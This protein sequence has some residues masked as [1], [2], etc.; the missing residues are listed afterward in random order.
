ML[1]NS[2]WILLGLGLC[3]APVLIHLLSRR[4]YRREPWAAMTFLRAALERRAKQLRLESVLLL[5]LRTLLV[6]LVV[7]AA[8]EPV[9]FA[10]DRYGGSREPLRRIIVVDLSASMGRRSLD[11]RPVDRA[12]REIEEVLNAAVPGD[13]FQLVRIVATPPWTLIRKETFD[14]QDV[15]AEL[16]RWDLTEERGDLE[17]TL[18]AVDDLLRESGAAASREVIVLSDLQRSNWLP[19]TPASRAAQQRLLA[20]IAERAK[21]RVVDVAVEAAADIGVADLRPAQPIASPGQESEWTAVLRN[22]GRATAAVRVEW[23]VGGELADSGSIDV[24]GQGEAA[25]RHRV[26]VADQETLEVEARLIVEDALAA[27]N[28]RFGAIP[29]RS[30]LKVVLVDGR[31]GLRPIDGAAGYLMT[32]LSRRGGSATNGL[33]VPLDCQ[34]LSE[35]ELAQLDLGD[36]DCLWLCDVAQLEPPVQ[37]RLEHFVER[38]GGLVVS[39]GDQTN[40]EAWN[41]WSGRLGGLLPV[42]LLPPRDAAEVETEG[43][44]FTLGTSTHPVVAPFIGNPD[45][46]LLTTRI[47]RYLDAELLPVQPGRRVLELSHGAPAIVEQAYGLGRVAVVLTSVDGRWE[48]WAVW[49]S[50]PP[51]VYNLAVYAASGAEPRR[52]LAVGEPIERTLL[53]SQG[54]VETTLLDPQDRRS[55][56]EPRCDAEECRVRFETTSAGFY[57]LE[58]GGP[59]HRRETVAV[60]LDPVE[61]LPEALDEAAL[62]RELLPKQRFVYGAGA[63]NWNGAETSPVARGS[64]AGLVIA[65]ALL[66]LLIEQLTAWRSRWGL[67]ALV[68]AAGGAIAWQ[69]IAINPWLTVALLA[70]VVSTGIVVRQRLTPSPQTGPGPRRST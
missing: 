51:L 32:A 24:P 50:F 37:K 18:T 61:T 44:T 29:V 65:T 35:P 16:D 33:R 36:V 34:V 20:R 63:A 27:D 54:K 58:F 69:G 45:A 28:R 68:L 7:L 53:P 15:R 41:A 47:R 39:V 13:S 60:N 26:R 49:P 2:P 59:I 22:F 57:R 9:F 25:L 4:T 56:A 14:P 23:W 12:R 17:K 40:V 30:A 48:N 10:A 46:G 66:V 8:A 5:L 55:T 64:L 19:E 43:V 52:A 6:A 21:L 67:L 62:G 31:P 70:M 3:A 38:G 42:K 1:F 11:D